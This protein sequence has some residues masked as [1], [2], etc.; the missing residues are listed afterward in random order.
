[1]E[2]ELFEIKKGEYQYNGAKLN[3]TINSQGY[4][5]VQLKG[6]LRRL[7][8]L[9]A[10]R[11]IENPKGLPIVGHGD[12]NKLNNNIDNLQWISYS[13][14]SKKAYHSTP[15]MKSMHNH[16]RKTYTKII[17]Q[18]SDGNKKEF[19]TLRSVA[20]YL[21]RNVAG[22]YRCLNGEWKNCNGH[23]LKYE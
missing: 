13:D 5:Y 23:T 7:H 15:S 8:R 17:A 1:M 10:L 2:I 9:I 20:K 16:K 19:K 21:N 12:D 6:K 4:C 3:V 22:V 11:Y 18:D 14:N